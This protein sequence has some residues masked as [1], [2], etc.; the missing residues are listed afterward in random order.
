MKVGTDITKHL[1]IIVG[2]WSVVFLLGIMLHGTYTSGAVEGFVAG[3]HAG[4]PS[5]PPHQAA[6]PH[7]TAAMHAAK[8]C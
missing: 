3:T 6:K 8:K 7:C 5:P 1:Y 4:H 2:I